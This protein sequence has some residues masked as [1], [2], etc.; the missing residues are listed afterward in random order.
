MC[1]TLAVAWGIFSCRIWD[2]VPWS[3]IETRTL[4]WEHGVLLTTGLP[5]KPS[6]P[7]II[8][9][10]SCLAENFFFFFN[11]CCNGAANEIEAEVT[12]WELQKIFLKGPF[13][14]SPTLHSLSFCLKYGCDGW[15]SCSHFW[16]WDDLEDKSHLIKDTGIETLEKGIDFFEPQFLIC[17]T[18]AINMVCVT[19][20]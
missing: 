6:E 3:G 9:G 20:Y 14:F 18:G 11:L 16:L 12:G 8:K 13:T 17:K 19:R 2:L 5:G 4:H 10:S 15:S 1:P 7:Y